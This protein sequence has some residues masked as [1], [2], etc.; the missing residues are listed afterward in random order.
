M[1]EFIRQNPGIAGWEA[2]QR[3]QDAEQARELRTMQIDDAQ[4]RRAEEQSAS[5]ALQ[6]IYAQ[7]ATPESFERAA[8]APGLGARTR[9]DLGERGQKM[10]VHETERREKRAKDMADFLKAGLIGPA[11]QAARDAGITV[12]DTFWSDREQQ[13]KL[14]QKI[15]M[16]LKQSQVEANTSRAQFY[17]GEGRQTG[18][19]GRQSV[20]QQK[21]ALYKAAYPDKNDAEVLEMADGRKPP[22]PA[23]L[24]ARAFVIAQKATDHLGRPLYKTPE[25]QRRAADETL[26]YMLGGVDAAQPS[27]APPG[28]P[29]AAPAPGARG[30]AP[31]AA[32]AAQAA[33]AQPTAP[34]QTVN[35]GGVQGTFT[36][37][38]RDGKPV[39]RTP[40][41]R[42][43]VIED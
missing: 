25:D 34:Q 38:H 26:Q 28:Q 35:V 3:M 21:V 18:A 19:G 29:A 41:G 27:L 4:R 40:D 14:L 13:A 15:D 7:R 39:Y 1:V 11:Q 20:F 37:Q 36:G 23:D 22:N 5:D 32:P 33:P 10:R 2:G 42:Q 17:R 8:G 9:L 16:D 31:T 43:F 12:P 30:P 6:G 24:R